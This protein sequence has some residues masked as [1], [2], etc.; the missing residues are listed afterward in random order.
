MVAPLSHSFSNSEAFTSLDPD[1]GAGV[2][3]TPASLPLAALIGIIVALIVLLLIAGIFVVLWGRHGKTEHSNLNYDI[4]T[5]FHEE[6]MNGPGDEDGD[7]F[8][9]SSDVDS[10]FP[11]GI[12]GIDRKDDFA[13]NVEEMRMGFA[14]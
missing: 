6:N 10:L 13:L 4:E 9:E 7:P 1:G 8:G 14:S 5:E 12:Q 3:K 11:G 2:F